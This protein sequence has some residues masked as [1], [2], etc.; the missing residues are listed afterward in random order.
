MP[1]PLSVRSL[2]LLVSIFSEKSEAQF[3]VK[4]AR[5]IVEIADWAQAELQVRA[6][7]PLSKP[8]RKLKPSGA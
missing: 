5:C 7:V 4:H 2:E 3:A 8:E 1:E 6:P